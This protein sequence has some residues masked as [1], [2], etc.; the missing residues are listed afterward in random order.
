MSFKIVT[1][2]RGVNYGAF[3][4]AFSVLNIFDEFSDGK[5]EIYDCQN[6]IYRASEKN[7]K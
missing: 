5:C 7:D 3:L 2:H 4:Q 6:I 1:F